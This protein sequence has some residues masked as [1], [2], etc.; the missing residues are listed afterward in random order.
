MS[1]PK[2][3]GQS[4]QPMPEPVIRTTLPAKMTKKV[5]AMAMRINRAMGYLNY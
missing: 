1:K 2:H 3:L 4:G 5:M